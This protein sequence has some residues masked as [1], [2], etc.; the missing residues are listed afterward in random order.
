[1]DDKNWQNNLPTHILPYPI[2]E[3]GMPVKEITSSVIK[4][5]KIL[6]ENLNFQDFIM[7]SIFIQYGLA[8][9][10]KNGYQT[11]DRGPRLSCDRDVEEIN[12]RKLPI[13][14]PNVPKRNRTLRTMYNFHDSTDTLKF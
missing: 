8:N 12:S 4:D 5:S 13:L 9:A 14:I 6:T 3:K 2:Y 11:K 10:E 7:H 1:M